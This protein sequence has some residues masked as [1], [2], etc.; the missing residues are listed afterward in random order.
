MKHVCPRCNYETDRRCHIIEHLN[1]KK[2]CPVLN[3]DIPVAEVLESFKNFV[4]NHTCDECQKSFSHYSSLYRHIKT[5]HKEITINNNTTDNSNHHNTN[6]TTNNTNC[7]NTTN[8]ITNNNIN[9]NPT[10]HIQIRPFGQEL[11]DHVKDHEELKM[12]CLKKVRKEGVPTMFSAIWLNDEVPE[13]QNIK[14][15]SWCH[16]KKV[17]LFT[18]SGWVDSDADRPIDTCIETIL[19]ILMDKASQLLKDENENYRDT[20]PG[21]V[22]DQRNNSVQGIKCKKRN[23]GHSQIKNE[24]LTNLS[25]KAKK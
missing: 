11:L 7:H 10:I 18:T 9:I 22:F 8:N 14:F 15:K 16:P 2:P 4:K 3:K 17:K 20:N 24:I 25:D 13:N 23:S 21:E 19:D 5:V 6:N 1:R 12:D